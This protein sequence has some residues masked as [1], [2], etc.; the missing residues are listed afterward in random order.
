MIAYNTPTKTW[1]VTAPNGFGLMEQIGH[2][3]PTERA[4][5]AALARLRRPQAGRIETVTRT[6]RA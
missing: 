1:I 2:D 6:Y 3:H 5:L 4:A